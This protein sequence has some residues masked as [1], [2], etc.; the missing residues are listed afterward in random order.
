MSVTGRDLRI[1]DDAYTGDPDAPVGPPVLDAWVRFRDVPDD[2]PIHAGLLAQFTGHVSI[3]AALRPHAGHRPG[4]GPRH[5][6]DGDQRHLDLVP[7]R[8]P[9]RPVD[10]L[11]PPLHV[12]RRRHD[13][14]RVPGATTRHGALLASFT[15]DAMVRAF[16]DPA[17]R[18]RPDRAVSLTSGRGP[19]GTDP[20]GRFSVPVPPGTVYVEPHPRRVQAVLDG[21]TV[22][23]TER[24]LMVHRAGQPLA[25]VFPPDEVGDL[26]HEPEPEAAGLRPRAL[27]RGRRLVRGGP[28]SSSTTRRTRTTGSTAGPPAAACGSRSPA[29]PWSTPTTP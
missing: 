15:V 24:A 21:Q 7:R 11:R 5:A 16:A 1:V 9:G 10:A 8:G 3:A 28:A 26:P 6:V 14:R 2:Q 4:P 18:R 13:P 23:D 20:A 22:I 25:Y 27:G 29:P 12:R 19:L 17:Q